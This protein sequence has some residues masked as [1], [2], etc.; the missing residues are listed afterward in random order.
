MMYNRQ[1]KQTKLKQIIQYYGNRV[2][3]LIHKLPTKNKE[4]KMTIKKVWWWNEDIHTEWI[5]I[6]YYIYLKKTTIHLTTVVNQHSNYSV[7][8]S[9]LRVKTYSFC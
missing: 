7:S 4:K 2:L 8:T 6:K 1:L 9:E 5:D 3:I